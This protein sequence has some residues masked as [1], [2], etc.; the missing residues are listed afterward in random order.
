MTEDG[1]KK[2]RVQVSGPKFVA[3]AQTVYLR[4]ERVALAVSRTMALRI[5]NAL[6]WYKPNS[7]GK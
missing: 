7:R 5:A 4:Q 3:V 6:N 2:T 1:G